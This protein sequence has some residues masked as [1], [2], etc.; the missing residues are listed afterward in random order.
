VHCAL[1]ACRRE[2]RMDAF[3]DTRG[4]KTA[5]RPFANLLW[6]LV[7]ERKLKILHKHLMIQ[8]K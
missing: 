6:T 3:T 7:I 8:K 1:I 5:M 2:Q 4:D